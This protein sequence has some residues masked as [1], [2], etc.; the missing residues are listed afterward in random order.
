MVVEE[1]EE[2]MPGQA[3][4]AGLHPRRQT[5]STIYNVIGW[6]LTP[7]RAPPL[8]MTGLLYVIIGEGSSVAYWLS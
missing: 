3:G 1:V 5:G 8:I 4:V 2:A 7:L 6:Y